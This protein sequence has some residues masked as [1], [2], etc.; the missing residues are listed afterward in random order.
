MRELREKWLD[1]FISLGAP[2]DHNGEKIRPDTRTSIAIGNV[3]RLE[4]AGKNNLRLT[5]KV[6]GAKYDFSGFLNDNTPVANLLK[7]AKEK[8]VPICVRF[9]RKRKK[10]VDPSIPMTELTKDANTARDSIVNIV[11]G[12]FN[13]NNEEWVL[14][15]DAISNPEEDPEY[16]SIELKKAVYNTDGFFSSSTKKSPVVD[17]NWKTNHLISMFTYASEHNYDNKLDLDTN[18]LKILAN[19]MLKAVDQL[20]MRANGINEPNYNDYSHTKARGMLFSWM[21]INPLTKE[22]MTTK[23]GFNDWITRFLNDGV[24]IWE[25][26][27]A[28]VEKEN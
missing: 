17:T 4:E 16:V 2:V 3:V 25:W 7:Q 13:F 21:R 18:A 23:G 15:D 5:L 6:A 8:E 24:A 1:E 27:K 14:T 9:E 20:Q 28:E 10:G 26:A 12:V 19:Y 22:I 11:S